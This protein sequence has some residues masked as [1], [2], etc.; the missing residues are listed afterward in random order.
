M[1]MVIVVN[2]AQSNRIE[3]MLTDD[4]KSNGVG[5]LLKLNNFV[6]EMVVKGINDAMKKQFIETITL[7]SDVKLTDLFDDIDLESFCLIQE[8]INQIKKIY[9]PEVVTAEYLLYLDYSYLI[10]TGSINLNTIE[11]IYNKL[12]QLKLQKEA[13][14][15]KTNKL[16]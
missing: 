9:N 16:R 15:Q 7:V 6:N 2:S 12:N 3:M 14:K 11:I 10:E 8:L 1:T 5:Y 4:F 13:S